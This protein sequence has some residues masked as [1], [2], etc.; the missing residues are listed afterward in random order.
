MLSNKKRSE[1]ECI[2]DQ[3]RTHKFYTLFKQSYETNVTSQIDEIGGG[4]SNEIGD[5]VASAAI[6]AADEQAEAKQFV[7]LIE[8]AV[9]QLPE[10]EKN[11][12]EYRYMSKN[13]NY[14]SDYTVYEVHIPMSDKTYRKIRSRAFEKLSK[15]LSL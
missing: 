7:Y 15:M 5:K 10:I 14:I 9:N 8:S 12:I 1:I 6:K 13:H 4:R 3:Y 11:I 2:F